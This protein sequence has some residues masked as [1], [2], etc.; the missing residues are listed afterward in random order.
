MEN[1][2]LLP[3]TS[4]LNMVFNGVAP[5]TCLPRKSHA[6]I[7]DNRAQQVASPVSPD[8]PDHC[9]SHIESTTLTVQPHF[10]THLSVRFVDKQ[11]GMILP[12]SDTHSLSP[13]SN[14]TRQLLSEAQ[15]LAM[16]E[17]RRTGRR[18]TIMDVIL[19]SERP[20]AAAQPYRCAAKTRFPRVQ[21]TYASKAHLGN[22]ELYRL[23]QA[24]ITVL[25]AA[26]GRRTS[27]ERSTSL[28]PPNL[29]D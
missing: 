1:L 2:L 23:E 10:R 9:T 3:A 20:V 13:M 11:D 16:Y 24:A 4:A 7:T 28:W 26:Y 15:K 14:R 19:E 12:P 6:P 25:T 18:V 8:T 22:M 29:D 21:K 17:S 5:D 27:A